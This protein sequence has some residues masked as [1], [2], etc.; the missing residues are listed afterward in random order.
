MTNKRKAIILLMTV[1]V[2]TFVSS[3]RALRPPESCGLGGNANET[4]YGL[5]F[6][7]LDLLDVS[8][9]PGI[10]DRDGLPRF[11]EGQALNLWL[12]VK[13]DT[14]VRVCVEETRGGGEI[15]YDETTPLASGQNAITL[16][17]L[18]SG[19]YV[20]RM[21]IDGTLVRSVPFSVR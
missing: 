14:R 1:V 3:C 9:S 10:P 16:G 4:G 17:I 19:P 20:L 5:Y 13:S 21:S 6:E 12:Q 11:E 2:L 15:A 7:K 18:E 8:G